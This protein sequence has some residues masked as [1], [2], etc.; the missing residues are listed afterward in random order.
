MTATDTHEGKNL[1]ALQERFV[2]EM[3]RDPSSAVK[4]YRRAGGKGSE[5]SSARQCAAQLLANAGVKNALREARVELSA[6][7][8]MDASWIIRELRRTYRRCSQRVAILDS[9]GEPTGVYR[10]DSA[11]ANGALRTLQKYYPE[12]PKETARNG[13]EVK[14]ELIMRLGLD[15]DHFDEPSV[16]ERAEIK[17][18]GLRNY[19]ELRILRK[20]EAIREKLK[21]RGIDP[22]ATPIQPP[23]DTHPQ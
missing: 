15:A 7:S 4:A 5:G 14:A 2:Q 22:D 17:R 9:Q 3:V 12:R 16:E 10:F 11:G 1:T 23:Q 8:K 18:L 13:E 19:D 20:G 6:Q 21:R